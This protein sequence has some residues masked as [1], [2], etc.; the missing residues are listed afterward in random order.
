MT[1]QLTNEL[2]SKLTD[3]IN[4]KKSTEEL[5]SLSNSYADQSNELNKAFATWQ[6]Q[7]RNDVVAPA[8]GPAPRA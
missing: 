7:H 2:K 1:A 4:A 6:L 3:A 8:P 5:I